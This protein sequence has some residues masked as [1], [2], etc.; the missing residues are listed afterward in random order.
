VGREREVWFSVGD[1]TREG[2]RAFVFTE[3]TLVPLMSLIPKFL[4][5]EVVRDWLRTGERSSKIEW[6]WIS[7][8][9]DLFDEEES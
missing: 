2:A 4:A 6:F 1:E 8:L 5:Q 9:P 7:D 3:W